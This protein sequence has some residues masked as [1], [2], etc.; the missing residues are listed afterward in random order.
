MERKTL[1]LLFLLGLLAQSGHA[2]KPNLE[3]VFDEKSPPCTDLFRHVCTEKDE[4]IAFERRQQQGLMEDFIKVFGKHN[5]EDRIYPAVWKA[6]E[7]EW[8][9]SKAENIKCRFKNIDIDEKDFSDGNDYKI[10]KAFGKM[11]AYGRF[12][13]AGIS[14]GFADGVYYV[15]DSGMNE[16]IADNRTIGE[17]DN[18][19]VRGILTGFFGEFP[20]EMK[21][22]PPAQGVHYS[23]IRAQEYK[24]T[25]LGQSAMERLMTHLNATKKGSDSM[26]EIERYQAIFMSETFAGYGNVLLAHTLYTYKDELNPAVADELTELAKRLLKEIASNVEKSTWI[27]PADREGI[28]A[29][30]KENKIIIGITKKYRDLD[31]LK[32]MMGVYHAEFEKVKPEDECQMEMLSRAHSIAWHKLVYSGVGSIAPSPMLRH[33]DFSLFTP[34]AYHDVDTIRFFPAFI[35]IL[36]DYN[37]STSFKYGHIVSVI[38]HEIFHGLGI[39]ER[40]SLKHLQGVMETRTFKQGR[41]CLLDFYAEEQFCTHTLCPKASNKIDEGFADI[42][43]ARVVYSLLQEALRQSGYGSRKRWVISESGKLPL[44]N[45]RPPGVAEEQVLMSDTKSLSQEKD[46]FIGLQAALCQKAPNVTNV[47]YLM[48]VHPRAEIRVNAIAQQMAQFTRA[49]GCKKG[50]RNYMADKQCGLYSPIDGR[51]PERVPEPEVKHE[52][53]CI[54]KEL[55]SATNDGAAFRALSTAF[56]LLCATIMCLL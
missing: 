5:V 6:M 56:V 19:F 31:L 48:D 22:L 24:Y 52:S 42:E 32:R 3:L 25:I 10:G 17:I 37:R 46:F 40:R 45:W 1:S 55:I 21:N 41:Q 47:V 44:F 15:R 54:S 4:M 50:D 53:E 8:N 34:N 11:T 30:L 27:S 51:L 43:G 9:L 35:H 14:V 38:G 33:N 18:D 36:N 16:I 20:N 12:G 39:G 49:F 29:Y 23:N 2:A 28:T 7:K 26:S 13:E